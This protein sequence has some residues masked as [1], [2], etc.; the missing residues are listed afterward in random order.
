MQR[1][2][3]DNNPAREPILEALTSL[4]AKAKQNGY[5]LGI[6]SALPISMQTVTEWSQALESKGLML[7]PATVTPLM[8]GC[9]RSCAQACWKYCLI[10]FLMK[11]YE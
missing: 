7:V 9:W 6:V 8:S 5:A 1:A 10:I 3:I 4:E 2:V 11:N